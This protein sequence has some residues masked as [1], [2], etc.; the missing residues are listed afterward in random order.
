MGGLVENSRGCGCS[1]IFARRGAWGG[2]RLIS[3]VCVAAEWQGRQYRSSR[4]RMGSSAK[5]AVAGKRAGRLRITPRT[6]CAEGC[7][8]KGAG[9]TAFGFLAYVSVREP[10]DPPTSSVYRQ[11][12]PDHTVAQR[13][14]RPC[15]MTCQPTHAPR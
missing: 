2:S 5:A 1:T 11:S 8:F 4:G 12:T 15:A 7:G 14:F 10:E 13:R 3:P 9:D 6:Y